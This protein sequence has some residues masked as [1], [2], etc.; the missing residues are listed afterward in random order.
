VFAI[1]IAAGDGTMLVATRNFGDRLKELREAAGISMYELA[2]RSNVSAA[3]LSR[4]EE[5]DR[6]PQW[7]TVVKL[8]RAL[9]VSVSEFDAS[10]DVDPE[11]PPPPPPPAPPRR[12]GKK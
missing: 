12:R 2:K 3:S 11:P 8:A 10:E 5:G 6:D 7:Q 1:L 4:Y 9:G